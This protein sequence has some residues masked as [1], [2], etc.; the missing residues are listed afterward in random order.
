MQFKNSLKNYFKKL[1]FSKSERY[2]IFIF[3]T[4]FEVWNSTVKQTKKL[5][6]LIFI[7]NFF[8]F[9][10]M[11][12]CKNSNLTIIIRG[13]KVSLKKFDNEI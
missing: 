5:E 7:Q 2:Q 1:T 12:L 3:R 4:L 11:G 9:K 6:K 8:E 10:K 13:I